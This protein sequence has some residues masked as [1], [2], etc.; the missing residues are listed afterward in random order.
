MREFI[1]NRCGTK[2]YSA[3]VTGH[4][5]EKCGGQ[6]IEVEEKEQAVSIQAERKKKPKLTVLPGKG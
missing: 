1:C 3:A 5:C 2:W 6:L 4:P